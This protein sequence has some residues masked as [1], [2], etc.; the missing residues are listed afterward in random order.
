MNNESYAAEFWKLAGDYERHKETGDEGAM[1]GD[2]GE[3][4]NLASKMG[5]GLMRNKILETLMPP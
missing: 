2:A 4:A 5:A 3:L 1:M